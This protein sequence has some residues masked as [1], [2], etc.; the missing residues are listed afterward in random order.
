MVPWANREQMQA[1]RRTLLA[2]VASTST[3]A[4]VV[5]THENFPPWGRIVGDEASGYRWQRA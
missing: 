5:F 2:D 1:S 3:D 4:L